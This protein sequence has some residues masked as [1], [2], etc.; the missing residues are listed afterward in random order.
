MCSSRYTERTNERMCGCDEDR[1]MYIVSI[2]VS[3]RERCKEYKSHHTHTHMSSWAE[4]SRAYEWVS[5]RASEG[6]RASDGERGR[7]KRQE[8]TRV[9]MYGRAG[10]RIYEK[11]YGMVEEYERHLPRRSNYALSNVHFVQAT[12]A[13]CRRGALHGCR[14][15]SAQ[16]RT[17][18]DIR[19]T[20]LFIYTEQKKKIN[21]W[22]LVNGC[23]ILSLCCTTYA[24][25]FCCNGINMF[26][27]RSY[28]Q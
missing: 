3:E 9:C 16:D 25:F 23:T 13:P 5:E 8:R 27:A 22:P 19:T 7:P 17:T 12:E 4:L 6:E 15:D 24:V 11:G 1:C 28:F 10:W 26:V 21:I 14:D 18:A 2:R 20:R